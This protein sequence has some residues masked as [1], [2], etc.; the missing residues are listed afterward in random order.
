ME[1][2]EFMSLLSA[3]LYGLAA[4]EQQ[5]ILDYYNELILD[6]LESG[7]SESEVIAGFGSVNDISRRVRAEWPKSNIRPYQQPPQKSKMPKALKGLITFLL[8]LFV[9]LPIVLPL[10][11]VYFSLFVVL[12]ALIFASVAIGISGFISCVVF[13]YP[14]SFATGMFQFGAG[15]VLIALGLSL[16]IGLAALVKLYSKLTKL[17]FKASDNALKKWGEL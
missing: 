1:K 10:I 8:I 3:Q 9:G 17:I 7:L 4:D 13:I 11:I 5:R 16:T 12:L 6:G 15:L 2:K 14:A